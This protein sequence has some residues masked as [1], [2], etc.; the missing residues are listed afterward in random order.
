MEIITLNIPSGHIPIEGPRLQW[1]KIWPV[2]Q[3]PGPL[4]PCQM[5]GCLRASSST[6]PP[7][8]KQWSH[9]HPQLLPLAC[10]P[11]GDA[12]AHSGALPCSWA[13]H[14]S[15]GLQQAANRMYYCEPTTLWPS[16][17]YT[18]SRGRGRWPATD[19]AKVQIRG[20]EWAEHAAER[21]KKEMGESR[22]RRKACIKPSWLK[23]VTDFHLN[24]FK[25]TK[26]LMCG[27]L[28]LPK[29]QNDKLP[30]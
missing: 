3:S 24:I 14:S 6:N 19:S 26:T 13:S 7:G 4:A 16:E 28:W 11:Q 9:F 2:E 17:L 20:W 21:S 5:C 1:L 30:K 25:P 23:D 22:V 29:F 15:P 8:S 27:G 10:R 18:W 12:S